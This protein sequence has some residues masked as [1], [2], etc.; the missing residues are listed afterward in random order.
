MRRERGAVAATCRAKPNRVPFRMLPAAQPLVNTLRTGLAHVLINCDG[1]ALQPGSRASERSWLRDGAL[2]SEALFRLVHEDIA[3]DFLRRHAPHQFPIGKVLC[4]VDA[5]GVDPVPENDS[6]G[7][8]IF[9]VS[10][11]YRYIHDRALL[12]SVRRAAGR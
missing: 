9:L 4:C 1:P 12:A 10:E 2:T 5:R 6:H 8:L 11:L 7:E 3:R